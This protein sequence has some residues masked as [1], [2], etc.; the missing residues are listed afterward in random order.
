MRTTSKLLAVALTAALQSAT[1]GTVLLNFEDLQTSE[2]LTNRYAGVSASGAAW[3]VTSEACS[4]GPNQDAGD[5]PFIRTGSCGALWL[6]ASLANVVNKDQSLTLSLADGFINSLSFVFS[7]G[8]QNSKL[9]VH[10]Y[11]DAGQELGIGLSGLSGSPCS[12]YTYCNWSNTVNLSFTGVAR[13]VTFTAPDQTIMI[14]DI[15]FTTPA[16][17][18]RL[19]EPTSAALALGALGALVWAGKRKT[20]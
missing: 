15:S 10:V 14:D 18:G 19:P 7:S 3:A 11:D 17:T 8:S 16:A 12:S 13:S 6:T 20:R 4:Y 9:G 2:Q 1:A 5:G